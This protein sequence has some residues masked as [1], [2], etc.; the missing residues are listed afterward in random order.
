M[1]KAGVFSA[2]GTYKME[3]CVWQGVCAGQL[4]K[5]NCGPVQGKCTVGL[6]QGESGS[7]SL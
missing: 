2:G 5:F 6:E 7:E 3:G 1:I 4:L